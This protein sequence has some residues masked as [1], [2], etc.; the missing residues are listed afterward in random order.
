[1]IVVVRSE[2]HTVG[3]VGAAQSVRVRYG[4]RDLDLTVAVNV[5]LAADYDTDAIL[6]LDRRDFRA[7]RPLGRLKSFRVRPADLP[8]R[9][10][11]GR[12]RSSGAGYCGMNS[13]AAG[14]RLVPTSAALCV[15]IEPAL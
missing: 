13:E 1:M 4:A 14:R 9:R 8:L 7:V 2:G 6:T 3:N 11:N 15:R 10:G 12:L 5:A